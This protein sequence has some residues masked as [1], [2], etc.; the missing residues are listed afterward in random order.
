MTSTPAPA[1]AAVPTTTTTSMASDVITE[2]T[3]LDAVSADRLTDELPELIEADDNR[4]LNGQQSQLAARLSPSSEEGDD[5]E[6][7]LDDESLAKA[8]GVGGTASSTAAVKATAKRHL[9]ELR[10]YL[11]NFSQPDERIKALFNRYSALLQDHKKFERELILIKR[12][13]DQLMKEKDS[14]SLELTKT[15][16]MKGKLEN[17]C[18]ELQKQNKAVVED[19]K[20]IANEEHK[21]RE[22]M[23]KKFQSTMREYTS[24][25]DEESHKV[26]GDNTKLREKLANFAEQYEIREQ[27]FLTQLKTKDLER[28]LLEAKLKQQT[29]IAAQEALK[30]QAYKEQITFLAKTENELRAQLS[31]YAEKFEQFQ[32]TLTKSNDVFTTFKQEME[33]M[34]K[35]IK[36]SEK[37]NS[38]LRKKCEQ[39]D[40]TLLELAEERN[41]YRKQVESLTQQ[42][43][44]L[45]ALCRALQTERNKNRSADGAPTTTP[46]N[47]P[48]NPAPSPAAQPLSP[49]P[50]PV[51]AAS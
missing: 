44:Q 38:V 30:A 20:R 17:L 41:N 28:Q 11:D 9:K 13:C 4:E 14:L 50:A 48:T 46:T 22:E 24:K 47:G 35:T 33:R 45:E 49:T 37:E 42:K 19:S 5:D 16:T 2:E 21:K 39:T 34:T 7:Y 15:N 31:L 18:R 26:A 1:S 25:V 32:D 23:A 10:Q 3:E 29:E 27:H 43:K 51:Q 36:K 6:E 12:R 8:P 40:Y